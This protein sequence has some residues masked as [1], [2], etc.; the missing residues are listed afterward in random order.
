MK[1]NIEFYL[2]QIKSFRYWGI[3]H[4]TYGRF[5]GRFIYMGNQCIFFG[6]NRVG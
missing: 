5:R 3:T 2:G 4:G 6:Y 1:A